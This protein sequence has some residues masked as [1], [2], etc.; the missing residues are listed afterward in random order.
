MRR[1]PPTPRPGADVAAARS[2]PGAPM[3]GDAPPH[4]P[5]C[6]PGAAAAAAAA[7]CSAAAAGRHASAAARSDPNDYRGRAR[8]PGATQSHPPPQ[9]PAGSRGDAVH[10]RPRTG[11]MAAATT[12][13]RAARDAGRRA[14]RRGRQRR[15]HVQRG[16]ACSGRHEAS[17]YAAGGEVGGVDGES[18]R[19]LADAPLRRLAAG[20]CRARRRGGPRRRRRHRPEADSG[21]RLGVW[22]VDPRQGRKPPRPRFDARRRP[23]QSHP[24]SVGAARTRRTPGCGG[25]IGSISSLLIG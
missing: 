25:S 13:A 21:G 5:G 19:P 8:R 10:P 23:D 17:G 20:W 14:G 9:P 11:G 6:A 22:G 16:A 18:T 2:P 24:P 15:R 7:L 3:A 12:T 1:R 4:G